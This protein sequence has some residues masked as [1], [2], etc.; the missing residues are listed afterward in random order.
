MC[1]LLECVT[2]RLYEM[3]RFF[4]LVQFYSDQQHAR[5][6]S[7][8]K[9]NSLTYWCSNSENNDK[10]NYTFRIDRI[11]PFRWLII[12]FTWC[13][14]FRLCF[15]VIHFIKKIF[16]LAPNF[17][18]CVKIAHSVKFYGLDPIRFWKEP[19]EYSETKQKQAIAA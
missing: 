17:S 9:K 3:I 5:Y 19:T 10:S 7:I 13:K 8:C 11:R 4:F 16:F 1:C 14:W 15:I 18:T 12:W 6:L 2:L